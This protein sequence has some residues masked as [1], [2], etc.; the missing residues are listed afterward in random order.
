M[1][2]RGCHSVKPQQAAIIKQTISEK[3]CGNESKNLTAGPRH[4]VVLK[5]NHGIKHWDNL[6]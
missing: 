1:G 2:A 6:S 4:L 5:R 3:S